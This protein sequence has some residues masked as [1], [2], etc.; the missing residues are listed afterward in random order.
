MAD[1]EVSHIDTEGEDADE[2]RDKILDEVTQLRRLKGW[3]KTDTAHKAKWE[4]QANIDFGFVACDQWNET[5]EKFMSAEGRVPVVFNRC[6]TIIK[7]IA[8]SEI[9]GRLDT[10]YI[11]RKVQ[12]TKANE[13]LSAASDWMADECDAE[14]EQSEAFEAALI[15][16]MGWTEARLSYDEDPEGMYE[17]TEVDPREMGWDAKSQKKNIADARRVH[18][19]R[20]ISITEARAMFPKYKDEDLDA[21]WAN[22]LGNDSKDPKPVEDKLHQGDEADDPVVADRSDVTLVHMQWWEKEGYW[23]VAQEQDMTQPQMGQQP[24]APEQLSEDDY[25][26]YATRA[27][28]IGIKYQSVKMMRKVFKQAFIGN[29]ILGGITATPCPT[30]F[31]FH[32]ITGERDRKSKTFFGLVR[33][34]RDPQMWANKMLS[35]TLHIANT[36]AKGGIIAE[37]EAF[38]GQRQAEESYAQPNVITWAAKGAVSGEKIMPKPGTGDPSVYLKLLEFA[39]AS[40]RDVTGVNL[41]LLGLRDANQ[42]GILEAQRKQAAMTVLA[43]LFNSLR[44]FRK[45]IGRFRLYMIQEHLSDGRLIRIKGQDGAESI[46]LIREH[47]FGDYDTV[48]ADA[49]TSPNQKE[50]TWALINQMVPLIKDQLTPEVILILLEYS[51]LPTD[52][53]EKLRTAKQNAEQQAQQQQQAQDQANQEDRQLIHAATQAKTAKDAAAAQKAGAEAQ[54]VGASAPSDAL[55]SRAQAAKAVAEAQAIGQKGAGDAHASHAK[56][57]EHFARA[58]T[59]MADANATNLQAHSDAVQA[60]GDIAQTA[61]DVAETK[62]ASVAQSG[63]DNLTMQNMMADL[64]QKM[65]DLFDS[66]LQTAMAVQGQQHDQSMAEKALEGDTELQKMKLKQPKAK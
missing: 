64:M 30:E 11:P 34:M 32:C 36:T 62:R 33:V 55:L 37:R 63:I 41:E 61:A 5:D 17:E 20:Q 57:A 48:V 40:I 58:Q 51:P 18:R 56:A 28:Q 22:K 6:L 13:L 2:A 59:H 46:P 21:T 52:V 60:H 14:D 45:G 25:K 9:N 53:L 1:E 27:K 19:T 54:T 10:R 29:K 50:A 23:L 42:P 12:D 4:K 65:S 49:P 44:R 15:C 47:T 35:N 24:P 31:S 8:G 26:I 43:G 66:K 38:D 7:S 16:G 3:H 39:I